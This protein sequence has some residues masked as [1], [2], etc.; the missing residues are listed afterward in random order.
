MCDAG[1]IESDDTAA[2][3]DLSSALFGDG[4]SEFLESHWEKAPSAME[5][6]SD[7]IADLDLDAV[8]EIITTAALANDIRLVQAVDGDLDTKPCPTWMS[9][10]VDPHALFRSYADGWTI[11][12]NS[13]D[14]AG[15]RLSALAAAFDDLF[16]VHVNINLY[17]SPPGAQGFL[18]HVDGHDVIILPIAGEKVWE[19]LDCPVL[20]PLEHQPTPPPPDGAPTATMTLGPGRMLYIPRGWRHRAWSDGA[21]CAHLTVGFHPIRIADIVASLVRA[22]AERDVTLR[23]S[24]SKSD[25]LAIDRDGILELASAVSNLDVDIADDVVADVRGTVQDRLHRNSGFAPGGTLM[26]I[27]RLQEL[28]LDTRLHHRS[29]HEYSVHVD[30]DAALLIVGNTTMSMPSWVEPALGYVAATAVFSPRDLPG[31]TES[32]ALVLAR[33]LVREG[34]LIPVPEGNP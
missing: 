23:R 34:L 20:L 16:D 6:R 3:S 28:H 4:F 11:I 17:L 10:R 5:V 21:G 14:R 8:E 27:D 7:P 13:V 31:L 2:A 9:G 25:A 15:G 32:S 30:N 12:A 26:A 33:R 18:P 1:S 19:I 22:V 29:G 24:I